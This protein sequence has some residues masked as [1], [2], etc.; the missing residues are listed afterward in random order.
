MDQIIVGYGTRSEKK[1]KAALAAIA[2]TGL[3][4]VLACANTKTGEMEQ[5]MGRFGDPA[6]LSEGMA[7]AK[8]R[9]TEALLAVPEAEYG[10]G[11]ESQLLEIDMSS[12]LDITVTCLW[13]RGATSGIYTTSTGICCPAEYVRESLKA[14]RRVTAGKFFAAATGAAHDD[15]HRHITG[16]RLARDEMIEQAIFAAL[17]LCFPPISA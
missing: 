3:P 15:W 12:Y 7:G 2:R 13:K 9:A 8:T 1:V 16:G 4:L 10:L 5:P 6:P 14:G 11:S 17:V